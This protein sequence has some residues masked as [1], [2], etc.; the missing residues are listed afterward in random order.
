M[1]ARRLILLALSV[2]LVSGLYLR[3]SDESV[4]SWITTS[5]K[6]AATEAY[7]RTVDYSRIWFELF[8]QTNSDSSLR[9]DAG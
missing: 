2:L 4:R 8:R 7:V 6:P 5:A 3:E 9:L 1:K